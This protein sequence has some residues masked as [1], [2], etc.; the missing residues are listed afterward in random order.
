MDSDDFFER[1]MVEELI[2]RAQKTDADVIIFT[3]RQFED[4]L[5]RKGEILLRPQLQFA[6]NK[7]VF[8]YKDCPK[9]ICQIADFVAWN[10]FFKREFI[11]REQLRFDRIP[12]S[13]DCYPSIIGTVL[14]KRISVINK[15][16][17]NYRI[18]TGTSQTDA[19]AK[20][21]EAAYKG[22]YSVVSKLIEKGLY[23]EVK[24]SYLN[25]ALRVAQ[26]YYDDMNDFK[27]LHFLHYT[28][29]NEVF[30]KIG[31]EKLEADYFYDFRQWQWYELIHNNTP[32]EIVYKVMRSYGADMNTAILRFQFPKGVRRCEK[33]VLIGKGLA[34]RYWYAQNLLGKYCDIVCWVNSETD[35]PLG[36]RYD[37]ILY[38][39]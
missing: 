23:E 32:D 36:L 15:P 4:D 9:Y 26:D 5:Q 28:L 3:A 31:A 17:V 18:R 21:P 11:E 29:L 25:I 34:G 13:D 27:N 33:V 2:S 39:K 38:A 12:I 8:S 37:R 30:P 19:H 14:A 24:Q 35:I 6:P 16:Y 1:E 10:K 7:E 20:H 22:A